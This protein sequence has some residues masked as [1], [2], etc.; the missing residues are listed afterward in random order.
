M[1]TRRVQASGWIDTAA[2]L[3]IGLGMGYLLLRGLEMASAVAWV[4]CG[5]GAVAKIIAAWMAAPPSGRED[6]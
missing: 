6:S 1:S 5:L 3:S 4:L 2:S